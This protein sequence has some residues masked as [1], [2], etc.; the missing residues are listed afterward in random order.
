MYILRKPEIKYNKSLEDI[1]EISQ[2]QYNII[3]NSSRYLKQNGIL[4]YS[5]C[6]IEREENIKLI[7]RF[8]SENPMYKFVP[9]EEVNCDDMKI[10]GRDGYIELFPNI[11]GTDGFFIAK[12]IKIY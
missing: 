4:V 9:I 11:H 2:M 1:K 10:N 8:L 7:N 12:L 6:T 3:R 5:T